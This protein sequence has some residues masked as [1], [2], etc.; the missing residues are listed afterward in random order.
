MHMTHWDAFAVR[1]GMNQFIRKYFI[2]LAEIE[3]HAPTRER[4][5]KIIGI[6]TQ[7]LIV[8]CVISHYYPSGSFISDSGEI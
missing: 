7:A 1:R 3:P 4:D 6:H 2:E 5:G 8:L